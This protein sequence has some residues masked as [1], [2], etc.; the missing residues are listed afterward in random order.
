MNFATTAL[1]VAILSVSP[2]NPPETTATAYGLTMS[3]QMETGLT[4]DAAATGKRKRNRVSTFKPSK[5]GT[6][7]HGRRANELTGSQNS[8]ADDD[9][10]F[11][12]ND[13]IFV[14]YEEDENGNPVPGTK[15][16][17]CTGE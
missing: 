12:G 9:G 8:A 14:I 10:T 15:E 4:I 1:A 2:S 11:C 7:R 5:A 17:G 6:K 13:D 3:E 16:Y